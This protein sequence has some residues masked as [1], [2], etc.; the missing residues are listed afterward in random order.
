LSGAVTGTGG[1]VKSG[2]GTVSLTG[3]YAYTGSTEING[4]TLS[5]ATAS[6][7]DTGSVAIATGGVLNLPHGQEDTVAEFL[8]DGL[9]QGTGVYSNATHPTLITGTGSIR[10]A[11][12]DPFFDWIDGFTSI[13]NPADKTKTAD[14]DQDGL[15]NLEEFALNGNPAAGGN[16]GKVRARVEAV[17]GNQALVITLPVRNG[18]VFDNT[19]G[20]GADATIDKVVY[21]V[22][23][24]NNLTAF[25]QGVTEIA[26]S[27]A[28]MPALETGWT[29]HSFRLNGNIGGGT[30]RGPKGF[31][32]VQIVE[33]AP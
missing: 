22:R 14:P 3:T 25:D 30:P 32:D 5:L 11:P 24:S 19:P 10:V 16:S 15:T 17:A 4:G 26:V 7:S 33:A 27:A 18:G 23:G 2:G 6:L 31:L 13:T 12:A 21:T 9:P 28:D 1:L 20:P 29:Y 8:I